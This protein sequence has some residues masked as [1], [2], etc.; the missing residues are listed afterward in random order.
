MERVPQKPIVQEEVEVFHEDFLGR[1]VNGE[2][3]FEKVETVS[4]IKTKGEFEEV[5]ENIDRNVHGVAYS[6]GSFEGGIRIE[7][8]EG[9]RE[10]LI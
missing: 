10:R 7:E 3:E 8:E 5:R 1:K 6:L 4:E 2:I 9:E